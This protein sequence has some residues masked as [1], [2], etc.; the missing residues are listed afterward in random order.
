MAGSA[1]P[2]LIGSVQTGLTSPLTKHLSCTIIR[3]SML[4]TSCVLRTCPER[5]APG[6]TRHAMLLTVF[7]LQTL[8]CCAM[9]QWP[10]ML[11]DTELP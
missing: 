7:W 8:R 1:Q 5:P 11:L 4:G 6:C 10:A 3:H 9:R 2:H